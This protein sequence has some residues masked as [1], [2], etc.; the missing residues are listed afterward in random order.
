MI[1]VVP[2]VTN[3]SGEPDFSAVDAATASVAA[4]LQA[5]SLVI[6][7]TTLPVHTTRRR[8]APALALGSGLRLGDDFIAV[9]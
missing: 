1:I 8:L 2:L 4:G 9:P 5:G 7:E 3:A 6:Y